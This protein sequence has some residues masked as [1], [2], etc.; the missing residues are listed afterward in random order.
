MGDFRRE[1]PEPRDVVVTFR[2]T[3]AE[4]Q[5]LGELA[6][7]LGVRGHAEVLRQALDYFLSHSPEGRR[8]ARQ[9]RSQ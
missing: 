4:K 1:R 5:M 9:A 8:A 7:A 3:A 6:T 2:A